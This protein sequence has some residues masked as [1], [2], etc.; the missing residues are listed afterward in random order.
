MIVQ[1]RLYGRLPGSQSNI[2]RPRMARWI[3]KAVLA[4]FDWGRDPCIAAAH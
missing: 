2:C 3:D 1:D 4:D